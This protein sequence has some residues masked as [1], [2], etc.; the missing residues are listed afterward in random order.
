MTLRNSLNVVVCACAAVAA[1]AFLTPQ[2]KSAELLAQRD[3]AAA[4][5]EPLSLDIASTCQ[6]GGGLFMIANRG[7]KWPRTGNL[8]LYYADDHSLIGER[9]LRLAGNQRITFVVKDTVMKG[10]PV[11]V[12]ID[13]GWYKRAF[14][15]D[16]SLSCM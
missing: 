16:A 1:T 4:P 2:A 13:P 8:K 10:R 6:D 7:T 5:P 12:W 14:K 3:I 9:R 15:A 11:A